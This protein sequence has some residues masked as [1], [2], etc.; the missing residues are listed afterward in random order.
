MRFAIT[1]QNRSPLW[2]GL[3]LSGAAIAIA[4]WQLARFFTEQPD[5]AVEKRDGDL[6]VRTYAP[7]VVAETTV[8]A[9]AWEEVLDE[10]F[11]RL[12]RYIFGGN[13]Q[14]EKIAMT[15]PVNATVDHQVVF[16]MPKGR[17]IATLPDPEDRRV[18]LRERPAER[19]A[20]LRFRGTYR[21]KRIEEKR[22]E[23]L[24]RVRAA[25]LLPLSEPVFA[26]YD[27]PSTL[28]FLRRVEVWVRV[29]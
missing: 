12:A 20:A 15:A 5:Y 8:G 19:V 6:E 17:S 10:G 18:R 4:R 2:V 28:P 11:R 26:G 1:R 3:A 13:D 9:R 7:R 16:T 14:H 29:A 25:G 27:G 22:R 24:Q 21:G 23:L